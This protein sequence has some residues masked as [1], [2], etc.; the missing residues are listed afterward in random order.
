MST[1][2]I[3][4]G[5]QNASRN[6]ERHPKC[7]WNSSQ[8]WGSEKTPTLSNR[9]ELCCGAMPSEMT[10][11]FQSSSGLRALLNVVSL[12]VMGFELLTFWSVALNLLHGFTTVLESSHSWIKYYWGPL[13]YLEA[14]FQ[15]IDGFFS[16][17]RN[18]KWRLIRWK[19]HRFM[20][21]HH[22]ASI[23]FSVPSNERCT[24]KRFRDD[25]INNTQLV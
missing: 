5:H 11:C 18:L 1:L 16:R 3:K 19:F 9:S 6:A 4:I 20:T 24:Q 23:G 14:L 25:D 22:S 8:R 12:V 13:F 21:L 10:Q 17:T 7:S 2:E 15:Q